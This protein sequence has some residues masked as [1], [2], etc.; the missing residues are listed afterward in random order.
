M[1]C[2]VCY[3][4]YYV[5]LAGI[6]GIGISLSLFAYFKSKPLAGLR[7]TFF[8]TACL[9]VILLCHFSIAIL[10]DFFLSP[11]QGLRASPPGDHA[12]YFF[13]FIYFFIATILTLRWS[14]FKKYLVIGLPLLM[15]IVIDIV[16]YNSWQNDATTR[17]LTQ[18]FISHSS[19]Y[20]GVE[21][22]TPQ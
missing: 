16:I 20:V 4:Y 7:N 5:Y 8:K 9:I 3:L 10:T 17:P 18:D 22:N 12:L 21:N 19:C 15:S 11:R 13:G 1:G 6:L 14:N 2:I